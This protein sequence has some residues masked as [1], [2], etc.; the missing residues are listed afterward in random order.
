MVNLEGRSW[1]D[2]SIEERKE[3]GRIGAQNVSDSIDGN[4]KYSY[5]KERRKECEDMGEHREPT[6]ASVIGHENFDLRP[7]YREDVRMWC[8]YCHTCYWREPTE[9]EANE[10]YEH[11]ESWRK[12]LDI[13]TSF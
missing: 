2:I 10:Y 8:T 5:L 9:E 4:G 6:Q 3:I 13:P 11:Q 12:I 1:N 7:S